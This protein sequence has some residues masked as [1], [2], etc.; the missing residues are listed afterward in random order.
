MATAN[1][2]TPYLLRGVGTGASTHLVSSSKYLNDAPIRDYW[3]A[4]HF[5][6]PLGK[7]SA[8]PSD[9]YRLH[10]ILMELQD[11]NRIEELFTAERARSPELDR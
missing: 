8:C 5:P 9:P 6:A 4:T 3:A 10:M 11:M 2:D 7:G 1:N